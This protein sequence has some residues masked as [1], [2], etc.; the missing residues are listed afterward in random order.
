M[1]NKQYVTVMID[2]LK[3]KNTLLEF[4]LSRTKSQEELIKGKKYD[5]INWKQFDVIIEEKDNAI[6]R[7]ESLDDGFQQ[8]FDKMKEEIDQNRSLY[9]SQIREMQ[10]MIRSLTDLGM[11]IQALEERNRQEIERIMMSSKKEIKGAKKKLKVSGA[12]IASMYGG[13][14]P[15]ES[16]QIDHK[17]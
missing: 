15:P 1:E 3:N 13:N 6:S 5:E 11:S 7:V 17:K 12:Y 8:L 4:L 9:A 16:T 14:I 10:D 2:S